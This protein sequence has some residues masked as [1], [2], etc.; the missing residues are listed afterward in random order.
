MASLQNLFHEEQW[1]ILS[2]VY[3]DSGAVVLMECTL[4]WE[5]RP[6][7]HSTLASIVEL[8]QEH[9][10]S[11]AT[12]FATDDSCVGVRVVCGEGIGHGSE[13]FVALSREGRLAWVAYF[14]ESNPFTKAT[15]RDGRVIAT[16]NL[17][18]TWSFPIDHPEQVQVDWDS[19]ET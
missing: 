1:P 9:M 17:G 6:I 19:S 14:Q 13:G 10:T 4:G 15:I 7:A 16:N 18:H 5:V 3:F 8:N 12:L 2:G 11:L